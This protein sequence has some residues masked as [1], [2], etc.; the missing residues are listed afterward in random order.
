MCNIISL[1]RNTFSNNY[2]KNGGALIIAFDLATIATESLFTIDS[3]TFTN[4]RATLDG[5]A[6]YVIEKLDSLADP[7]L[8]KVVLDL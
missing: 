5:G 1:K 2:A 3:C 6:I 7:N 8:V 4:S